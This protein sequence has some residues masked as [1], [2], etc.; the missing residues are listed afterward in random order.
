MVCRTHKYANG[1][2][3]TRWIDPKTGRLNVKRDT[4]VGGDIKESVSRAANLAGGFFG[5]A[6]DALKK[7]KIGVGEQNFADGGRARLGSG[8]RFAALSKSVG[9]N[10]KVRDPDAVAASIGRNKFG[11]KKFAALSAAGRKRS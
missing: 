1:G 4:T 11:A 6:V 2:N 7:R 8:A 5:D 9:K 3:V 10:P